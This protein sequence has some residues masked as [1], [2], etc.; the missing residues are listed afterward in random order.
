[1]LD[2]KKAEHEPHQTSVFV[3]TWYSIMIYSLNDEAAV[4]M[5]GGVNDFWKIDVNNLY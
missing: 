2:A 4:F 3:P 5:M 1:M